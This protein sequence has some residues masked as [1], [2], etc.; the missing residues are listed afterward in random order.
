MKQYYAYLVEYENGMKS[1]Q[2]LP[3]T[4]EAVYVEGKFFP[5]SERLVLIHPHQKEV[6]DLI[7]KFDEEGNM[8]F[9]K[10][11]NAPQKER[12]RTLVNVNHQLGGEDIN[13]FLD[14]YVENADFA[15]DIM[16][17]AKLKPMI[18]PATS[19]ETAEEVKSNLIITE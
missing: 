18:Q 9:T 8:K 5:S 1:F 4:N 13:W 3:L 6:F 10:R 11:G 7:E 19:M 12:L 17:Q 14:T 15:K 16:E 2:L